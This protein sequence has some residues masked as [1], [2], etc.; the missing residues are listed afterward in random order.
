[1]NPD[2]E[3][4]VR[5]TVT[6]IRRLYA[7]YPWMPS[8]FRDLL[9]GKTYLPNNKLR[10]NLF[11]RADG[12]LGDGVYRSHFFGERNLVDLMLEAIKEQTRYSEF[13]LNRRKLAGAVKRSLE[14]SVCPSQRI[15]MSD[16]LC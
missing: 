9:D 5:R 11:N 15:F 12:F 8:A 13:A 2:D 10:V 3:A 7:A 1:V 16:K 14:S 4:D 6:E